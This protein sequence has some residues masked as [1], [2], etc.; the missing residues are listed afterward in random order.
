MCL[1]KRQE[2]F[3]KRELS[4]MAFLP[5]NVT[6]DRFHLGLADCESALSVLPMKA[7]ELGKPSR[8]QP[9]EFALIAR[10]TSETAL[11]CCRRTRRW[12]GVGNAIGDQTKATLAANR[13]TQVFPQA[14]PQL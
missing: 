14:A 13:T 8:I 5:G 1:Q 11:S 4:V 10:R 7:T 2:F 6:T 12:N 9:E 3:L